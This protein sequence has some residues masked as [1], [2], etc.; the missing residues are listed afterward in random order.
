MIAV[1][2]WESH[3]GT[4][5]LAVTFD[6]GMEVSKQVIYSADYRRDAIHS[7]YGLT[8]FDKLAKSGIAWICKR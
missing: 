4:L 8:Q 3:V 2:T 6:A 5:D 1:S 7:N